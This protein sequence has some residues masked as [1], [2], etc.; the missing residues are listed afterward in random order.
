[1]SQDTQG[2]TE[3]G[4]AVETIVGSR[5]AAA[6]EAMAEVSDYDQSEADELARA[7]AWAIYR[8]D[9]AESLVETTL[10]VTGLG[11]AADKRTKL[12]G[13]V[14]G[15]LDDALDVP[16]V[17]RVP[18]DRDGVVE[19]ARPVGV[20]GGVVPS[21]NPAPTVV[22]LAI[23]ALNGRNALVVSTS[24]AGLAP[25]EEAVEYIRTELAAVGAPRDLV[26]VL[27]RP[28]S[29]AKTRALL[30][31][32]DLVQVTGSADNVAAGQASGTPNY[33]VSAG[34]PV[35]V[36]DGSADIEATAAA[37]VPSASFDEG[38]AC[39]AE[40]CA[41][42]PAGTYDDLRAELR[43]AGG[44]LCDRA[45]TAALRETLFNDGHLDREAIGLPAPDLA[46]KAG[47]GDAVGADADLLVVEPDDVA[48][49]PLV[50][51]CLAPVLGTIAV[52]DRDDAFGVAERVLD[53]EGAGHSAAVHTDDR[54]VGTAA[55]CRLDV[56]RVVVNQ[57][58]AAAGGTFDNGLTHAYSLGGGTWA[59]N[60]LAENL[61]V[62]HF[63]QTTRVAFAED[64]DEPR[65]EAVFGDYEQFD[66]D[67]V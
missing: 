2:V 14:K 29:K 24:P 16:S 57:P 33:C 34:N 3:Q 49:D 8:A 44:F 55:G 52:A 38:I 54:S 15:I 6:R 4:P 46:T 20:V 21:T 65:A 28:A 63:V 32:A 35:A 37:L 7:V 48:T 51:E 41:V 45:E 10:S 12:R 64:P 25:V 42:A 9:H 66:A 1:M 22:N 53:R 61:S 56:C 40:S 36:V 31:Q 50:T 39:V 27:P 23:L 5:I 18:T 67:Q 59:G 58:T 19:F 60:Q 47:F 30:S 13:R 26:Q 17:G 11:N 43:A 62:H